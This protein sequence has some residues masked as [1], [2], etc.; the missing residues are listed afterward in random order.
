VSPNFFSGAQLNDIAF[1][2][3]SHQDALLAVLDVLPRH[4]AQTLQLSASP[5]ILKLSS[6]RHYLPP[7]AIFETRLSTSPVTST[8]WHASKH[9]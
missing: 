7:Q 5:H 3:Q 1:W 8:D 9:A 2:T 4:Q 6:Y